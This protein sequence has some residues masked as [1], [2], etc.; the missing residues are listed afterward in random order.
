MIAN[1]SEYRAKRRPHRVVVLWVP[2]LVGFDATIP[3]LV[4]GQAVDGSGAS[5]YE[6]L[7]CS[8]SAGPVPTTTGYS[9]TAQVGVEALETADTVIVPGTRDPAAR[10]DGR[11]SDEL[12]DAFARVRPGTRMVSICTG[13]AV[14]AAAGVFDGRRATT[15]WRFADDFARMYPDV[16]FDPTVLFVDDGD[17]LSSAGLAA[18]IDLCLHIIRRDHGSAV[19][20]AVARYCVVPPWREGGQAQ[21]IDRAVPDTDALSTSATRDWA[22]R[23]L[24]EPLTVSSLAAHARMSSRTFSRR[25]R[26][27][28]GMSPGSWLTDRRVGRARELLESGSLSIDAVAVQSGL[29]TADNMRHH[30]RR[31]L[32]TSP[33]SY[34]KTFSGSN[35]HRTS[36]DGGLAVEEV[37][38]ADVGGGGDLSAG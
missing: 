15:H 4:F 29:G 32:G 35:D 30:L 38:L 16:E 11:M 12:A 25:F 18:G 19:A 27:E 5:L 24:H 6:V 7:T 20:N 23:N 26:D 36:V 33:S 2:P 31:V 9:M 10:Q 21:F 13:A 34:R 17:V 14:L 37:D 22:L 1:M 8:L 28:T 3:N